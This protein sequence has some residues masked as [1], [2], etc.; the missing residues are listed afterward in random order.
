[1]RDDVKFRENGVVRV[2]RV[3][4][5]RWRR[6]ADLRRGALEVLFRDGSRHVWLRELAD[7][8]PTARS[9]R[10]RLLREVPGPGF[11]QPPPRANSR[12]ARRRRARM[13]A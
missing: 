9:A 8:A 12:E 6:T 7:A 10:D 11:R 13:A 1:M 5:G 3:L 2:G 4:V